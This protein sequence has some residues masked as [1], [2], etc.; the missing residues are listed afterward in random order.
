MPVEDH[1]EHDD[2]FEDRLGDA[3]RH[4][5]EDFEADRRAL[6]AA[7]TARGRRLVRRRRAAIAAGVA[8]VA[9]AGVGGALLVPSSG[10]G[11]GQQSVAAD[12]AIQSPPA[13]DDGEISAADLVR[14]LKG[15][16]PEGEFREEQGRGVG[17]GPG[18]YAQVVYDDGKGGGAV[19][20]GLNRVDPDSEMSRQVT[21]CP[22]R[23]QVPHDSCSTTTLPDG[24]TLMLFQGYEYPD[25]R[26]DTKWWAADLVTPQGQLVNVSEWNAE[27]EKD[28]PVSREEPPL[29]LAQLQKVATAAAWRAAIDTIPEEVR[30]PRAPTTEMAEADGAAITRTLVA[31]L[32]TG[33]A[34][35]TKGRPEAGYGYLVIDDG[36]GRSLVQIN[37]Q[38]DMSDAA[39][40][41]YG[42][43][44]EILPDG[45]KVATSQGPGEKGGSG[46]VM[47]TVD[48]MR[49]D[50]M[51]VVVSAFNSGSQH[52]AATRDTPALTM[53]Q[54]RAIA[55][56]AK[57]R[58]LIRS[59]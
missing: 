14:T 10:D 3:L 44:P 26:V 34:V 50:G 7:G 28:A 32:P 2:R 35:V 38:S 55:T 6:T 8:A 41:L 47:W 53:K 46:V 13:E 21:T 59:S 56:S 45:T 18:P 49:T 11:H 4:A 5:G 40:E 23:T 58:K 31:L 33:V 37:V 17:L 24:S 30:S 20:V 25:R 12:R 51:R 15:L 39:D 42:A 22:D 19:A 36:K 57:W 54:L 16:L 1:Q 43:D 27:A 52:D 9:F 48:T 29:S